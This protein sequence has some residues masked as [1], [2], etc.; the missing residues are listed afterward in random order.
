MA[1]SN[2]RMVQRSHVKYWLLEH[3]PPSIILSLW[4]TIESESDR[5]MLETVYL[6]LTGKLP[7]PQEQSQ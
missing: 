5:R 3:A 7:Q 4:E 6:E 2:L 1:D